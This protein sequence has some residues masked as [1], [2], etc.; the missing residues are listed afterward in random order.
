MTALL[1]SAIRTRC[2]GTALDRL[3][4]PDC[5]RQTKTAVQTRFGLPPRCARA[6][7]RHK[8][9]LPLVDA[10]AVAPESECRQVLLAW[11]MAGEGMLLRDAFRLVCACGRI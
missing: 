9:S 3:G 6:Q 4:V 5:S 1:T 2:S 8:L 10:D 11:L 7:S